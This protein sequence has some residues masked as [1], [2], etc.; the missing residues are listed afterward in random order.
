MNCFVKTWHL[1][2]K[3]KTKYDSYHYDFE[4]EDN[5]KFFEPT[6]KVCQDILNNLFKD[7]FHV[8]FNEQDAKL[9]GAESADS[10]TE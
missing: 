1:L 7:R 9:W 3:K 10:D 6:M 8:F 4:Y 2:K 5:D